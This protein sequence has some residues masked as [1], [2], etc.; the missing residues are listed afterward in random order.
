MRTT[1]ILLLTALSLSCSRGTFVLNG[2]I[3]GKDN[4][5]I[6]LSYMKTWMESTMDSA[7]ITNGTFRFRGKVDGATS[8]SLH[9]EPRPDYRGNP[10][11]AS[12]WIQEGKMSIEVTAG[13]LKE[14]SLTG[15]LANSENN[16]LENRGTLVTAGLR[17]V[18]GLLAA[19]QDPARQD[20]LR[21][22][23]DR[24]RQ[25]LQEIEDDF[26]REHPGSHISAYRT[27][28]RVNSLSLEESEARFAALDRHVRKGVM[29][30]ALDKE[31]RALRAG[32]PGSPAHLFR[33][34]ADIN[35]NPFDLA[36]LVGKKYILLDF[37]ASWCVPCRAGNPHLKE[38][39]E[40]YKD[41]LFVVCVS[42]DDSAPDKW[43]AAVEQDGLHDFYHVLRGLKR[44]PS[45]GFDRSESISDAFAIHSL[46]TKIL[47]DKSGTIISRH[48]GNTPA[49]DSKLKE[50]LGK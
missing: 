26:I 34:E 31:I 20:S 15:S 35:G 9:L 46:P 2:H 42:D 21:E 30:K 25:Q 48:V 47:I 4:G 43:R 36:T 1:I 3:D 24:H 8:A 14:Y 39:Y 19:E 45:G 11:V 10:D 37:W 49:L 22:L 33:K 32:S 29:G 7:T 12:F 5:T 23:L 16:F 28:F 38:L 50:L 13:N 27:L 41:D 18:N 44:T 6:Y 17:R 40:R